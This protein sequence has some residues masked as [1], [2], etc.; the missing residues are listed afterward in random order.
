MLFAEVVAAQPNL[1][2]G[3]A[4]L[5]PHLDEPLH[6]GFGVV[7][8]TIAIDGDATIW[9]VQPGRLLMNHRQNRHRR[10]S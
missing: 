1:H 2:R 8:V 7:I 6:D 4:Y 5:R 3:K 9:S 10:F